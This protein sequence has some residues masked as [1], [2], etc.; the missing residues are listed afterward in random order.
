MAKMI[1]AAGL[2]LVVSEGSHAPGE[3][4]DPAHPWDPMDVA[5]NLVSDI[6]TEKVLV[7]RTKDQWQ[8]SFCSCIN[9]GNIASWYQM[10]SSFYLVNECSEKGFTMRTGH[11]QD[12]RVEPL[13]GMMSCDVLKLVSYCLSHEAPEALPIW[14]HTCKDAH[15][16]VP[17]CD[18]DCNA[19]VP[20]AGRL[21]SVAMAL[22]SAVAVLG[23]GRL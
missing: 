10:A 15:Y 3:Q 17:A 1:L 20:R 13:Q 23:L 4:Y 14:N 9:N 19:A 6:L 5:A 12:R 8:S 18:V 7:A 16:T 22:V 11:M 21:G 2:L